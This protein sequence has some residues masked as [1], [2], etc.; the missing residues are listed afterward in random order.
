M[1]QMLPQNSDR[2]SNLREYQGRAFISGCQHFLM[3]RYNSLCC[4]L[5]WTV[6]ALFIVH[7]FSFPVYAGSMPVTS[8]TINLTIKQLLE[9]MSEPSQQRS[10]AIDMFLLGIF[11]QT[12]GKLWCDYSQ[13]KVDTLRDV[14]FGQLSELRADALSHR[15]APAVSDVLA[16]HFPCRD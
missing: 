3:S 5:G 13:F 14:V 8:N 10:D 11:D 7:V 2:A 12:E 1:R 9:E 4:G 15:A 6:L 16:K